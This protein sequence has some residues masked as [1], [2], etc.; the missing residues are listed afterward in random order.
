MQC[1]N[2]CPRCGYPDECVN[3]VIIE[4]SPVIQVWALATTLSHPNIFAMSNI[5]TTYTLNHIIFLEEE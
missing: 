2:I 3:D 5:Y 1:D 4:C